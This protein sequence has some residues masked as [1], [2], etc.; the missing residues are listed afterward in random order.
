MSK[1]IVFSSRLVPQIMKYHQTLTPS[2]THFH[3]MLYATLET[4]HIHL[5]H[6]IQFQLKHTK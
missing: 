1:K 6:H 4:F 5:I 2:G 3:L